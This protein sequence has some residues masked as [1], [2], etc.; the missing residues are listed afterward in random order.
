M[1]NHKEELAH[2]KFNLYLKRRAIYVWYGRLKER[3]VS[4]NSIA[5][6]FLYLS[7]DAKFKCSYQY[8]K[9]WSKKRK[10]LAKLPDDFKPHSI[11]KQSDK[12][13]VRKITN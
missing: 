11:L 7:L 2:E 13:N 9:K 8:Q 5:F 6:L 12:P 4:F 10:N 1:Q 3:Q